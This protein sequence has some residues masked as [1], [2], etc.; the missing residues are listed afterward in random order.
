MILDE[1][2]ER[3]FELL[4]EEACLSLLH[5]G[6]LGRVAVTL[7]AMPAIF[8]VNYHADSGSIYFMTGEGTKLA[9]AVRSA[10][11]AFETDDVDHHD[12]EG[13]SVLAV[14]VANEVIDE[15]ELAAMSS[16]LHPL[17]PDERTHLVRISPDFVSGR[18]IAFGRWAGP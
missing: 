11:V 10:V 4:D 9:A 5:Q 2:P 8:P 3:S 13:W 7:G 6:W 12:R 15:A 14:G 1:D 17:P 18:R 16:R